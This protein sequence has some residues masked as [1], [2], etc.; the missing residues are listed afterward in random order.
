MWKGKRIA[1]S[2]F[3]YLGYI[4]KKNG[5]D[6]GQI[7]ELKKKGNI[8]MKKVWDLGKRIFKDAFRR[9]MMLFRYFDT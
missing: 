6:D 4:L 5:R 3:K 9:R 8:V 7:R 2:E 1:V